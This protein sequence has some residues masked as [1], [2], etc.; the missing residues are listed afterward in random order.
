M[1]RAPLKSLALVIALLACV[2]AV[3]LAWQHHRASVAR[4]L[5]VQV[6]GGDG[7]G[8]P[9]AQP[10]DEHLDA[11]ALDRIARDPAAAGLSA[12]MVLRHGHLVYSRFA[13]G[14]GADSVVDS[15][16]F[17]D[18]LVA[19]AT[20]IAADSRLVR[21]PPILFEP[22][23]LRHLLE[24]ASRQS[25]A[26]YLGQHLWSRLNASAAWIGLPALG[27]PTPADCCFHARVQDWARV[28]ALLAN[29]GSFEDT[30]IV[31]ADWVR[32]MRQPQPSGS[33]GYG[34]ALPSHRPGS[35]S[36]EARDLFLLRGPGRWR[37]WIIPSLR[38]VVLYG[39]PGASTDGAR[40]G[41]GAAADD[42][43]ETRIPNLVLEAVTDRPAVPPGTTLLQQLVPGH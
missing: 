33:M 15:G 39:A 12:L 11:R 36:Y 37:L 13:A 6:R 26:E 27:A 42:W 10:S 1:S 40:S 38:L 43:D 14:T 29:D 35:A 5:R 7:G 18:A 4:A 16:S 25:Y 30:Q 41:N 8:L 17:A 31:S 3:A 19:L 20:G 23:Q 32:R 2:L 21:S 9:L 22:E 24:A 28:G 34:V